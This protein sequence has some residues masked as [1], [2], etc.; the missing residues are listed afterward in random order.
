MSILG[1]QMSI[2]GGFDRAVLRAHLAG[3]DCLQV[4]TR[5]TN[6]WRVRPITPHEPGRFQAALAKYGIAQTAAHTSYL[7]NL[8]S[9][10]ESLWRRS[11]ESFLLELTRAETLG[12]PYVITHPGAHMGAGEEVGVERIAEALN[13]VLRQA[14]RLRVRCLLENTA[15]QGTTL[16]WSPE[17]LAAILNR[18]RDPDRVGVCIDTCHLFAAGFALAKAQ[19]YR[20][21]MERLSNTFGLQKIMAFH[22]NDSRREL[23]SRADRHEHIGRGQIGLDAF[24]RLLADPR[25]RCV[26]MY[27]ETP[28]GQ[29]NGE[30]LDVVNLRV[31]RELLISPR[32][33]A[34][35]QN[36]PGP[37][38][39][40]CS[41]RSGPR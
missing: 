39:R 16:G 22:V 33:A 21:T 28:K 4:F 14:R 40:R 27:L 24:R 23:G 36:R 26:P 9:P 6:Q 37:P 11:L 12:I 32:P 30:D 29:E 41:S 20:R 18:V 8:A 17:H 13:Q 15:G 19:E 34:T 2:V 25:F 5:N 38:C 3:C 7:I 1:A 35:G 31:L 10:D